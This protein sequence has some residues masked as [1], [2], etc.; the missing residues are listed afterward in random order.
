MQSGISNLSPVAH[1]N[2]VPAQFVRSVMTMRSS[3]PPRFESTPIALSYLAPN[4]LSSSH[5][6]LRG[7]TAATSLHLNS[8]HG[9]STRLPL[10]HHTNDRL[11]AVSLIRSKTS[12]VLGEYTLQNP[13]NQQ[14]SVPSPQLRQKSCNLDC[15]CSPDAL[16]TFNPSLYHI[17]RNS[18]LL[19]DRT[20]ATEFFF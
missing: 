6:D 7:R 14:S 12:A 4:P 19:A 3:I 15:W 8:S 20:S 18:S 1:P 10:L 9:H 11:W 13:P 2:Q 5:W 16:L 17:S